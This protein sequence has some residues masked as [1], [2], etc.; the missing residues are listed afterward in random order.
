MVTDIVWLSL[1]FVGSVEAI[2]A[3]A[4]AAMR[5]RT[6]LNGKCEAV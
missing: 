3:N 5:A 4:A 2:V 6:V 1:Y